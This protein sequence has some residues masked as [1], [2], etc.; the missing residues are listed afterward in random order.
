MAGC[1]GVRIEVWV[2]ARV[3]VGG[4]GSELRIGLG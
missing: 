4:L 2:R 3:V 1:L